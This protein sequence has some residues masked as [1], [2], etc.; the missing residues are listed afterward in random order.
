MIST[1]FLAML[2]FLET[3]FDTRDND[4][5]EKMIFEF[6]VMVDTCKSSFKLA[7]IACLY[8]SNIAP[9]DRSGS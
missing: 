8:A 6:L 5:K 9:A 3:N 4:T 2:S 1:S 7:D